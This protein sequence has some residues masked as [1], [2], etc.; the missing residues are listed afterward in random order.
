[1]SGTDALRTALVSDGL[2]GE[3]SEHLSAHLSSLMLLP[4]REAQLAMLKEQCHASG[5]PALTGGNKRRDAV[6]LAGEVSRHRFAIVGRHGRVVD[7]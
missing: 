5:M 1:M 6:R 2:L 7:Q 4:S 3:H